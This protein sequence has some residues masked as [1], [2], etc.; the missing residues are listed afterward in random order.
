MSR[1]RIRRLAAKVLHHGQ[2]DDSELSQIEFKDALRFPLRGCCRCLGGR[3]RAMMLF[4]SIT[5][6]SKGMFRP[7]CR[8]GATI[9]SAASLFS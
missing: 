8:H 4:G 1:S 7:Y 2:G 9:Y 5:L 6:L 3:V